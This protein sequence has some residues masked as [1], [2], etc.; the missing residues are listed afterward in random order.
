MMRPDA[1][2]HTLSTALTIDERLRI[3]RALAQAGFG[4]SLG[5]RTILLAYADS[6][7]VRDAVG[8]HTRVAVLAG[9]AR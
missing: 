6:T 1:R 8:E 9:K 4:P 7:R 3:E 5:V 2:R